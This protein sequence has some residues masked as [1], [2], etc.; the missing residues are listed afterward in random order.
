MSARLPYPVAQGNRCLEH[1]IPVAFPVI[2][3]SHA[4]TYIESRLVIERRARPRGARPL[5][6]GGGGG[7]VARVGGK[8][9]GRLLGQS[10]ARD[11]G[12]P[13][14]DEAGPGGKHGGG[15]GPGPKS[16]EKG[17]RPPTG[18]SGGSRTQGGAVEGGRAGAC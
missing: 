2:R 3:R 10:G 15:R 13:H 6:L 17:R 7:R 12:D 14:G 8:S 9:G 5:R 11:Y 4:R 1:P 16:V 18:G